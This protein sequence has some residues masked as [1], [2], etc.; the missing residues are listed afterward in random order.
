LKIENE[1]KGSYFICN[2]KFVTFIDA[3]KQQLIAYAASVYML[4][5]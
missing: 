5:I 4:T 2:S 3:K 1:E